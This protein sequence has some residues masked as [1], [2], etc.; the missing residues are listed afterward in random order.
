MRNIAKKWT[1]PIRDEKP[2]INRFARN[3]R[4]D[5]RNDQKLLTQKG[6][7]SAFVVLSNKGNVARVGLPR[8]STPLQLVR[9]DFLEKTPLNDLL[10][11]FPGISIQS[12]S[13]G[14]AQ[15]PK[16]LTDSS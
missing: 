10:D 12:L 13:T 4:K 16:G 7:S 15:E 5:F 14:S 11:W 3:L 8:G 6:G 1:M 2:A 9:D